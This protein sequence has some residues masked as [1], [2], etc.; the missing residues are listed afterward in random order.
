MY[1]ETLDSYVT[2]IRQVAILFSYSKPQILKVFK[3]TLP[4]ILYWVL[5][6][7]ENLRQVVETAKRILTK[8]KIDRQLVGQSFSTPF[9]SMKDGYAS[10]RVTF[11]M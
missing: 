11:D 9:M 6:P 1:A 10:K 7:T 4:T 5:F 8:E 2:H 3:N